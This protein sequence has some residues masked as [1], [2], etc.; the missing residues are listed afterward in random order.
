MSRFIFTLLIMV[1]TQVPHLLAQEPPSNLPPEVSI[2][3]PAKTLVLFAVEQPVLIRAA[4]YDLDGSIAEVRLLVN[5][6]PIASDFQSPYEFAYTPTFYGNFNIQAEAVDNLGARRLSA[7]RL[8]QTTRIMDNLSSQQPPAITG[9]NLV[10][11]SSNVNATHQKGEPQH[12]GV[13]GGKSVWFSW[14][15]TVTGTVIMDTAGSDF[16]TVLAVYTNATLQITSVTNL[17]AVAANDNDSELAPLSRV[18]FTAF[19]NTTYH[20]AVDGRDGFA[21]NVELAIRQSRSSAAPNDFLATAARLVDG[22]ILGTNAGASKEVGEPDHAGNAGGASVWWRLDNNT[23]APGTIR[24][25]T[26]GS[27][28]DTIVAVYTN[29]WSSGRPPVT[30]PPM[31][32]L[33]LIAA[34]DDAAGTNRTSELSFTVS[35][36]ATYWIVVDGYNGAEGSIRLGIA[37]QT[38]QTRPLNDAFAA[39]TLLT[40]SSAVTDVNTSLA[41]SEF[42]EPVQ[43]TTN[44]TSKSVWYRWVAPASGPVYVSTAWSSFDT[45]LAVYSGSALTNLLPVAFNDDDSGLRTSAAVFNAL[46][47]AEYRIGVAGYRGASGD[48]VLTLNQ[49]K[50]V[51]PRI[52][53]QWDG[54]KIALTVAGSGDILLLEASSDLVRWEPVRI[55][56]AAEEIVELEPSQEI[57]KQFYRVRSDE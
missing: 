30:P 39:A 54:G 27:S 55:L 36:L 12:A 16:D 4:A 2:T 49:P 41:S 43:L 46:E 26:F 53:T 38:T 8:I 50:V 52:I 35:G 32:E 6:T 5:G 47:G 48:L 17:V 40:G 56:N 7:T 22:T 11:Y 37:R 42:R 25:S 3:S 20:I 29:Q 57:S 21:G 18:K 45:V 44:G 10:L 51:L 15:P 13:P 1:L 31:S 33:R 14:R 24:L 23:F 28:F 19:A 9:T 34:N